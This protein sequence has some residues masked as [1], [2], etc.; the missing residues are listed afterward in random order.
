MTRRVPEPNV[1]G[2]AMRARTAAGSSPK[3][4]QMATNEHG[5]CAASLANQARTSPPSRVLGG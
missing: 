3:T 4:S 2:P 5:Q 1:A